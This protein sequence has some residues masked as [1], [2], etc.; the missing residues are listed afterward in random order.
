MAAQSSRDTGISPSASPTGSTARPATSSSSRPVFSIGQVLA[1]LQPEFPDLTPSKLRFLEDQNLVTPYRTPASNY[2]KFSV[3]DVERLRLVLTLQRDQYLPLKVIRDH[4]DA[5]DA[6]TALALPSAIGLSATSVLS[7]RPRFTRE[8]LF[9]AAGATANLLQ[10]SVSAGLMVAADS[11]S[12]EDL[13][14]LIALAQLQRSGIEPRHLSV[15][16]ATAEKEFALIERALAPVAKRQGTA[17][18][19]KAVERAHEIA[20]H[21]DVVRGQ[22]LR[23][24]ISRNAGQ[25]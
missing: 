12:E 19:A 24:V 5:M 18:R 2:R 20:V 17:S 7:A 8:E 25:A 23:S 13:T 15:L 9:R 1:K 21:M 3:N 6:G 11:F 22:I 14:L 4:L 10:D 16:K